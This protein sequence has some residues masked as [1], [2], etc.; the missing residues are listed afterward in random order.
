MFSVIIPLYNKEK[1]IERTLGSVFSQTYRNFEVIIVNDGS[2]DD[3]VSVI[4]KLEYDQLTL[5]HQKNAGVSA[6]RNHGARIARF[7]YLVFLDGDDTWE[8]DFLEELSLLIEEFP[9]CGIYGTNNYF[10]YP[11]GKKIVEDYSYLFEGK[12]TGIIEDYFGVFAQFQKSPFS[13]SNICIPAKV[14]HE[15]GGYRLGVKLTEDSDLWCRIALQYP[16]AFT[17]K[18]LATY[19]LGLEGST[20]TILEEKE[21]QVSITLREALERGK[22]PSSLIGSVVRLIAF[23]KL[24]LI[25]RALLTGNKRI[26]FKNVFSLPVLKYYPIELLKCFLSLLVPNFVFNR[27]RS[28]TR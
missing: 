4:E 22:V 28:L 6:A 13:N 7:P 10:I 14:Y 26:A 8:V 5:V 24:A 16:V 2:T 21:Y 23:Q 15:L 1:F 12:P 9:S 17:N 11:N 19:F 25:K 18:P 27:L 20:H 3:G